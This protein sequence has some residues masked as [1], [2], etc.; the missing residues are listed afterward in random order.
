MYGALSYLL[1]LLD[2]EKQRGGRQE[3]GGRFYSHHMLGKATK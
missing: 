2:L 1:Y 3:A